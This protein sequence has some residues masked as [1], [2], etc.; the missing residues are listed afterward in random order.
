MK[1]VI[2]NWKMNMDFNKVTN[3]LESL[4]KD[5]T[6]INNNTTVILSPSFIHIPIV[7]MFVDKYKNI[8]IA[9]QDISLYD[10]GAHTGSI[11]IDQ[12]KDFCDFCILGHSELKESKDITFK[13]VEKCLLNNI[14]PILCVPNPLEQTEKYSMIEIL[15]SLPEQVLTVWE[16]PSNISKG[17][18]YNEKPIMEIENKISEMSKLLNNKTIIYGGS[19]NE[20]NSQE[21]AKIEQLSGV[22][23]G[24]A[25]LNTNS[26][27]QIIGD[28]ER[29]IK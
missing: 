13:K 20:K 24:N 17:G 18:V 19:V 23:I 2:A 7:K 27:F 16:D 11:G 5:N 9:A 26:F 28:F 29:H 1:Y 4:E 21:L 8:K 10:M 12:I 25:S 15:N 14:I 22:L 3:W 6:V